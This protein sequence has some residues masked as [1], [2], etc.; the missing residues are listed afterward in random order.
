[1]AVIDN[2]ESGPGLPFDIARHASEA[3]A[4]L[5]RSGVSPIAAPG[6]RR[7]VN[8]DC[9][10]VPEII[11]PRDN[12][13]HVGQNSTDH[14]ISTNCAIMKPRQPRS[15]YEITDERTKVQITT[16]VVSMVE[17]ASC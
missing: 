4:P 15:L 12:S 6:R 9:P 3:C 8:G 11:L 16:L 7:A 1:V 2:S 10:E 5:R 13:G 14:R 17:R